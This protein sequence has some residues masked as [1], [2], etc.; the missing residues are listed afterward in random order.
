MLHT[1]KASL[2]SFGAV[3]RKRYPPV[4][5]ADSDM[6]GLTVNVLN[7]RSHMADVKSQVSKMV[8]QMKKMDESERLLAE[9]LNRDG[10]TNQSSWPAI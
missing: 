8:S 9:R 1:A 5:L 2:P 4:V 3:Y 10:T 7:V 6:F